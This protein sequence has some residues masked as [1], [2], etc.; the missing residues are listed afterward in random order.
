MLITKIFCYT[1]KSIQRWIPGYRNTSDK[2][3]ENICRI[4][5]V[6]VVDRQRKNRSKKGRLLLC[7]LSLFCLILTSNIVSFDIIENATG[8][9]QNYHDVV[10][11]TRIKNRIQGSEETK[12]QQ[13]VCILAGPHKTG[14]SSIQTNLYRWSRETIKFDDAKFQPLAKPIIRWIW[15]V[16]TKIAEVENSDAK[17]WGWTPSKVFYPMMEVL[18]DS[19][20]YVNSERALYKKYS[21]EEILGMYKE[22]IGSYWNQGYDVAFGTEAMDV[23]VKVPE[24][25]SIVRNISMHILPDSI[26]GDQVTVVVVYRSPKIKHLIS[27]WHQN[28]NKPTSENKFH[29]WITGTDNTFGSLDSLGMV[30]MFLKET[31]W[32]VALIDLDGVGRDG[33]DISNFVACVVLGEVCTGKRLKGLNG[34]DPVV[35]N[36]R[37]DKRPPNVPNR[38]L[39]E[40]ESIL[41]TYDCNYPNILGGKYE[42]LEIFYPDSMLKI[43]SACEKMG[44]KDFPRSLAE[45]RQQIKDIAEKYGVLW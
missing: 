12:A 14:T 22:T 41:Q 16:P 21:G 26:G 13:R 2:A 7:I 44:E 45:M 9:D 28:C 11:E 35:T 34:G 17:A 6:L 43:L 31:D 29:Q 4:D 37:G 5:H 33:Y 30:D 38:T 39:D 42:R 8:R 19:K 27:M 20:D 18:R 32:K 3:K 1:L 40:M 10:D 36:V 24:G 23:I 25:A 15:P